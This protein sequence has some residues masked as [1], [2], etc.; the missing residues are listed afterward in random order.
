MKAEDVAEW[1]ERRGKVL[2]AMDGHETVNGDYAAAI[3]AL[4]EERDRLR[5]ALKD[6][7]DALELFVDTGAKHREPYETPLS[8]YDRARAALEPRK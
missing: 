5:V 4:I 6:A 2:K 7:A 8:A 3:R 1:H